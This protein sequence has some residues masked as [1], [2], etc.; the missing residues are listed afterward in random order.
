MSM[1]SLIRWRPTKF[2]Q[3]LQKGRAAFILFI[4]TFALAL[5]CNGGVKNS[6]SP[7]TAPSITTQPLSQTLNQGDP[8]VLSVIVSGTTPFTYQWKKDGTNLSAANQAAFTLASAQPSDAGSYSVIVSNAGGTVTSSP[9]V[10]TINSLPVIT[11]FTASPTLL[12]IGGGAILSWDVNGA[13]TLSVDNGVGDLTAPTGT[14]NVIPT[15]TTTFTLSATNVAG[16][17]TAKA[18]VTVDP[19]PFAITNLVATPLVT[20][21]GSQSLLSW[22][23]SGIPVSLTL[24]GIPT[25]GISAPVSPVRRQVYTLAGA[26]GA[27]SDSRSIQVAAQGIDLL[28]G[29]VG[30]SGNLDGSGMTA[31][32]NRPMGVVV[33]ANNTT[34]VSDTL[35]H[36]IRKIDPSGVVSTFAGASGIAG[37]QDGPVQSARFHNPIGLALDGVGNLFVA[38]SVNNTIRK[39]TPDGVVST[40]AGTPGVPPSGVDG[41][42][43]AARFYAPT[44]LVIDSSGNLFVADTYMS[45][46]RKVTPS[47][48]V[49]T[50]AGQAGVSGSL[51]GLGTAAQFNQ[52]CGLALDGIGNLFV[53]DCAAQIIRKIDSTGRVSTIAGTPGV[54]GLADGIGSSA[55]F[56]APYGLAMDGNGNLFVADSQYG[57]IRKITSSGLVS[58]IAGAPGGGS[59]DGTGTSARFNL[60]SL[61]AMDKSGDLVIADSFNHDIRKMNVAG[62]VSTVAG[63]PPVTG[64]NDGTTDLARFNKTNGIGMDG[65]GSIYVADYRNHTIRKISPNGMVSTLAGSPGVPGSADG[66]GPVARFNNPFG[67]A[68]ASNGTVYVA[69]TGN[70]I[71]R[72]VDPTGLVTTVAG[73]AGLVGSS[74]GTGSLARFNGP[75]GLALDLAGNLFIVD[76]TNFNIRKM[77][78]SGVVTTLAGLAGTPGSS[79]GTGTS[80]R[81][82]APRNIAINSTGT[83]FVTDTANHTVRRISNTGEVTTLAGSPGVTGT[84][85]GTGSVARFN[86]PSGV[87]IDG[88]G[89]LYIADSLNHTIRKVDPTGIVSTIVGQPGKSGFLLGP[90][91]GC[92]DGPDYVATTPDG[93]LLVTMQNG[94]IQVTAPQ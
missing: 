58:T 64:S 17:T 36:T 9:A 79:D 85:D 72:S 37:V 27:G 54:M 53:A 82:Y 89:I 39:I 33:D 23:Y 59:S 87:A 78:P 15:A 50:L 31:R 63:N 71:I 21:Y 32:F 61:I 73:T 62:M 69:D 86:A 4:I 13:T 7:P 94:V 28:A 1:K 11:S 26:N 90:L 12:P 60:P 20:P 77:T 74:D 24:N 88:N 81:F 80:A 83:L 92:L 19:T 57:L 49:T 55:Q 46:I 52:P 22:S 47:G 43:P 56:F 25:S 2:M 8:L 40:L 70:H 66:L 75:I 67:I 48:V 3:Q 10:V 84:T 44:G 65:S 6:P 18:I 30:G 68:V 45:T 29:N 42:G 76:N 16:T 41:Q 34:Y 91:P 51:D 93:D 14:K 38:D 5:S 35:N